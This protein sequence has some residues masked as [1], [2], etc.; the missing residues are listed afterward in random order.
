M[1]H[2]ITFIGGGNMARSIVAG[3]IKQ[4]TESSKIRVIEPDAQTAAALRLD[5]SIATFPELSKDNIQSDYLILAVKPQILK[6]VCSNL[7]P[8]LADS[9]SIL[10][11]IAAGIKTTSICKWIANKSIPTIRAMPNTPAMISLSATGLFCDNQLSQSVKESIENIF[12]AIGNS[13]WLAR[14]EDLDTV[15]ALSGS[16]PAYF[17]LF[18][19]QLIQAGIEAGLS[20]EQAHNL[21]IQTAI[22]ASQMALMSKTQSEK[23]LD[24][25]SILRDKVTSKGGTTEAGIKTL[26]EENF[27]EAI[28]KAVNAAKTRSIE[29]SSEYG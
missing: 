19:E 11:S 26:I 18:C 17:F 4:G 15:T 3:L 29:L 16:G 8:F 21:V 2:L 27:T 6:S 22:G 14:E 25:L 9:K 12:S 5:F 23:N 13:I 10:I 20:H 1:D 28:R 7:A 24:S